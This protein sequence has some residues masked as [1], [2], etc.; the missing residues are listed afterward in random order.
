MEFQRQIIS[1]CTPCRRGGSS[2]P[3]V[4]QAFQIRVLYAPNQR[5]GFQADHF[6]RG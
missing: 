3:I 2:D 6:W 4:F 1:D 5:V